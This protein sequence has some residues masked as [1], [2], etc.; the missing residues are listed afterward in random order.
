MK[1]PRRAKMSSEALG[2]QVMANRLCR[3]GPRCTHTLPP[4]LVQPKVVKERNETVRKHT[5]KLA[6]QVSMRRLPLSVV[7]LE[8]LQFTQQGK[9]QDSEAETLVFSSCVSDASQSPGRLSPTCSIFQPLQGLGSSFET[10]NAE[11]ER[12]FSEAASGSL[13]LTKLED[14]SFVNRDSLF[15][16]KQTFSRHLVKL[17]RRGQTFSRP[18][19]KL[20]RRLPR[21]LSWRILARLRH[22]S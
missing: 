5:S 9:R 17:P 2:R 13:S 12:Q 3:R 16:F 10:S 20:P 4:H 22:L 6:G 19:V 21:R 8:C 18:L 7:E 11:S 1:K 15:L 14:I